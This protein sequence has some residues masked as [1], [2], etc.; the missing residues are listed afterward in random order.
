MKF[1]GCK[2]SLLAEFSISRR[3]A[4]IYDIHDVHPND[5]RSKMLKRRKR[6][7]DRIALTQQD[8]ART[9]GNL[10][11]EDVQGREQNFDSWKD[12]AGKRA[13]HICI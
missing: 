12:D 9:M 13:R 11:A 8:G 1:H 7:H 5:D 4:A 3:M 2:L 10:N 6:M